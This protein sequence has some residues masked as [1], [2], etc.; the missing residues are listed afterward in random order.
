DHLAGWD[1]TY[2]GKIVPQGTYTWTLSTKDMNNDKK[3]KYEGSFSVL[4]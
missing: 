1:G 3:Y 2:H 4:R